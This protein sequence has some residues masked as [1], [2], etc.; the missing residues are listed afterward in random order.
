MATFNYKN[1]Y[2]TYGNYTVSNNERNFRISSFHNLHKID[3]DNDLEALIK[4]KT[5][6][7]RRDNPPSLI[8]LDVAIN[9]AIIAH[10]ESKNN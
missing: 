9:E 5:A 6:L 1:A 7:S 3:A 2:R 4:L 10:A 8:P